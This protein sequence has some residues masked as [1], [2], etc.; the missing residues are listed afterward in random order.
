M[1]EH[2]GYTIT[3]QNSAEDALTL[4]AAQPDKFELVITDMTMP[5]ISGDRLAGELKKIRSDIPILLCT[6]FNELV[7]KEKAD[8]LG[9]RGFL[10]KPV[11]M[12][13]LAAMVRG[14]LD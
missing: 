6:G 1:L 5:T 11:K 9:I 8:A 14:L 7:T 2:L 13:D 12:A 4:F 3:T 10:M